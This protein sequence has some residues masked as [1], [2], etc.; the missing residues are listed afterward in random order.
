LHGG[1]VFLLV[2]LQNLVAAFTFGARFK[3]GRS[4][5]RGG[6]ADSTPLFDE[7]CV[8]VVEGVMELLKT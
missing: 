6:T 4:Q 5:R 2:Y 7:R 3:E 8:S 1:L